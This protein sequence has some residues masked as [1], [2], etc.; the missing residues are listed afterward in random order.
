MIEN[1]IIL[2]NKLLVLTPD[3]LAQVRGFLQSPLW[4]KFLSKIACK[5][6]SAFCAGAMAGDRDAFS[7]GRASAR[8]NQICGWELYESAIFF[9]LN[10]PEVLKQV[11]EETYPDEG[12]LPTAP[13]PVQKKPRKSKTP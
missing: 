1:P 5:K 4:I 2:A 13:Q 6:P 9:A 12:V 8:L 11:T 3:E 10:P 7:D